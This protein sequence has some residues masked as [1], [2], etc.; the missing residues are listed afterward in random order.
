MAGTQ[1]KERGVRNENEGVFFPQK[2]ISSE[3]GG[4]GLLGWMC[5][6]KAEMM[7]ERV[8]KTDKK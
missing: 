7:G 1:N 3:R 4:D 8:I 5:R 6:E 2:E